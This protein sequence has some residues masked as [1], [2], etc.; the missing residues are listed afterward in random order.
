MNV[1]DS[2]EST[3]TNTVHFVACQVSETEKWTIFTLLDSRKAQL[4]K[5]FKKT[6]KKRANIFAQSTY[7]SSKNSKDSPNSGQV[8][9]LFS[10]RDLKK[11]ISD[12]LNEGNQMVNIL[13]KQLTNVLEKTNRW[14][15]F[16]VQIQ[17]IG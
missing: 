14:S 10:L 4:L 13:F 12:A 2:L 15:Q 3:N 11:N 7:N 17:T 6:T 16:V 8:L 5:K 1:W 9:K